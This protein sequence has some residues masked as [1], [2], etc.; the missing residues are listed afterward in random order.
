MPAAPPLNPIQGHS[1]A[2]VGVGSGKPQ[3][4]HFFFFF[5]LA[6]PRSL[7]GFPGGSSVKNSSANA[8]DAG[9]IP[10]LGRYLREGNGNPPQYSCLGK[11]MDRR[12]WQATVSGVAQ[13]QTRLSN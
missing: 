7:Q 6:A 11:Y 2:L 10:E 1:G 3:S 12:A 8:G 4:L 13:S 5:F 9:S